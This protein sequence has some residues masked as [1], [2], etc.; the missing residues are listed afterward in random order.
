MT[1]SLPRLLTATGLALALLAPAAAH[2]QTQ[3]QTDLPVGEA[4]GVRL[5]EDHGGLVL[6]FSH[7]SAKLRER[8]NSRYAWMECTEL[9]D[10][11]TNGF[12]GNLD[13]APHGRRV[14]T[15]FASSNADFCD[16]FLRSHTVKRHGSRHRVARR[17]LFSIPLTQAGAVYLDEESKTR[18]MFTIGVLASLIKEDQ[19]LPGNPTY[20]QL[21]EE[22][23]KLARVVVQLPA[24]GDTPPPK[25]VG[26]YSDGQEHVALAMLSASGRRL[27][28]ERAADGVLSTNV[29]GYLFDDRF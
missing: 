2:A 11:F 14:S 8:I 3:T 26:Y 12:G 15:G 19:K 20:A 24:P 18:N 28:I 6:I 29:A 13:V 16:F 4:R 21:V 9:G 22:Y 1:T 23:P 10:V 5:V 17:V 25:R 7:R 27:F